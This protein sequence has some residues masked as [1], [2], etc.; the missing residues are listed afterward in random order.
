MFDIEYY[1]DNQVI[2]FDNELW[3]IVFRFKSLEDHYIYINLITDE[4][5]FHYNTSDYT[6]FPLFGKY[7][8]FELLLEAIPRIKK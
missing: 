6:N 5:A 4:Y 1:S 8:T 3:L 2:S 7:E